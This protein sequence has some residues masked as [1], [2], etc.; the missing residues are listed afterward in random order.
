MVGHHSINAK[1]APVP[2]RACRHVPVAGAAY[3]VGLLI[4]TVPVGVSMNAASIA[5]VLRETRARWVAM[6]S[7]ETTPLTSIQRW[8]GADGP[9]FET[10]A[11]FERSQLRDELRSAGG[12]WLDRDFAYY[13]RTGYPV[14]LIGYDGESPLMRLEYVMVEP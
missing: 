6:R 9:L 4:N 11:V 13:G 2:S 8:A 5:E 7:H 10:I 14:T 3:M 12:A 1:T